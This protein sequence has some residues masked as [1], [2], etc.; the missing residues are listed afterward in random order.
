MTHRTHAGLAYRVDGAGP[1]ALLL[2]PAF[3]HGGAFDGEVAAFPDRT[4]VRVDL[5]GHGATRDHRDA[6]TMDAVAPALAGILD[7][8]NL[9]VVDVL[10]ASLGSL[11]AQDFARR[12]P[13][14][15]RSLTVLGGYEVT[16]PTTAKAQQSEILSWLP[17][18]LFT[19]KRFRDY[20]AGISV[21]TPRG[22]ERF[23]ELAARF[24]ARDMLSLRGMDKVIAPTRDDVL[25]CPLCIVVGEHDIPVVLDASRRWHAAAPA[26][27]FHVIDGAGHCANLDDPSAFQAVWTEFLASLG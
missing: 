23:R 3:T 2:H 21:H 20:V 4:L 6:P 18:L 19:P 9:D 24:R 26:S 12:F 27:R 15:V 10:G 22:Q 7:A 25:T 11:V 1:P 13:T 8:E 14:R 16:D 5:P 17:K